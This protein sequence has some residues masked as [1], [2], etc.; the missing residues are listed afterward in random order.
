MTSR[1]GSAWPSGVVTFLFT[2][3]QGSTRLWEEHPVAMQSALARHDDLVGAAIA[4]HGGRV[5]KMTGDGAMAVFERSDDALSAALDAQGALAVEEWGETGPLVVRMGVHTG[6]AQHRDHDYFGPT[7]NRAARV[8]A[9][10]N[11]GQILCTR[12]SSDLAGDTFVLTSLGYHRLRDLGAADELFQ[13]GGGA[14]P[15]LRS[16]D[17]VPTNLPTV[18]TDLIGRSDDVARIASLVETERLVTLTGVGGVGKTRLALAAAASTTESFPDGVWF[19]ELAATSSSDEITRAITG[20]IGAPALDLSSLAVYL[21]GRRTLLVLDNCEHVLA[22]ASAVAAAIMVA[23]PEPAIVATSREPLGVGGEI[24][25]SVRSLD[26][27]DPDA[28]DADIAAASAVRLFVER[29]TAATDRFMLSSSNVSDVAAICAQLDG[30][31]LA[32]ELA[33]ARV[34][35]MPPGEIARRLGERFRLLSAGRGALER[36]RTLQAAVSWS[37]DLLSGHEKAVFRR[38]AVFPSTFEL[39]AAEYVAGSGEIDVIGALVHL[40]DQSLVEH[41]TTTRALPT[42]RDP[43]TVRRRPSC[44]RRGDRRP[45]RPPHEPLSGSRRHARRTR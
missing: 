9:V 33:A 18:L 2:D 24:V 19:V 15:A 11:G 16:V 41:D 44:R 45:P 12:T 1:T 7:V 10:A 13:V 14:F 5:V 32:I 21:A 31:P 28:D 25:R 17:A 3:L 27:P 8:A 20:A 40:V 35:A 38:L 39:D 36:H 42:L 43:P 23:G 22:D 6:D 26:L 34:R 30:I 37:H 4:S 29:A